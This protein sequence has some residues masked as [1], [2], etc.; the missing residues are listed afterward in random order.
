METILDVNKR[1][2]NIVT[3]MSWATAI[4]IGCGGA[5]SWVTLYAALGGFG[6]IILYDHDKLEY[7]NLNRTLYRTSDVGRSKVDAL[8]ELIGERRPACA[9]I[10]Y[11]RKCVDIN[12]LT[13]AYVFDC[14]DSTQFKRLVEAGY[15]T[16][17]DIWRSYVK[18]GYDGFEVTY[19]ATT[20]NF[21]LGED[22]PYTIVDSIFS[23]AS[24]L[25][26]LAVTEVMS[27]TL[28]SF[29]LDSRITSFDVRDILKQQL[30]K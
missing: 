20:K 11:A 25:A 6:N 27:P 10:P 19:D 23:S 1:Q 7:T 30:K 29:S 21:A 24:I 18:L 3:D 13:D 26:A 9:V 2:D 22:S 14:T 16:G 28:G 15:K 8:A 17:A 12:E 5:G 4:V